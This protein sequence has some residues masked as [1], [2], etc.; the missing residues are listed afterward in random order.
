MQQ[1]GVRPKL[2]DLFLNVFFEP[3]TD[4]LFVD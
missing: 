2:L 3:W 1:R 4:D